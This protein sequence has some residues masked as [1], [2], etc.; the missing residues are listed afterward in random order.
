MD[1][2]WLTLGK[3]A[4]ARYGQLSVFEFLFTVSILSA[5]LAYVFWQKGGAI[6]RVVLNKSGT[7]YVRSA[8]IIDFAYA[9]ILFIFKEVNEIPMSTTWV[10]VG[11]LCG[12][13]FAVYRQHDPNK[14][15][16]T[17]FPIVAQDFFKI[18]FGLALSVLLVLAVAYLDRT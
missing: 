9:F 18:L 4:F 15:L 2:H 7:R 16:K 17:I 13:E 1:C 11:L 10:F 5:G 14:H 8:T 6:Q 12:R 3:L